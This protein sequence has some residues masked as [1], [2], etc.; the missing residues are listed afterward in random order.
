MR[1]RRVV[2]SASVI[3]ISV[4]RYKLRIKHKLKISY[5]DEPSVIILFGQQMT[6]SNDF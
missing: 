3:V 5:R 2:D 6:E 1:R 4:I